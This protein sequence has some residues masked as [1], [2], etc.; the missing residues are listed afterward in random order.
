[1]F[2]YDICHLCR[3]FCSRQFDW[4]KSTWSRIFY[5][6]ILG[7]FFFKF[8]AKYYHIKLTSNLN[9]NRTLRIPT[10]LKRRGH[11]DNFLKVAL[12][13]LLVL[14]WSGLRDA[15]WELEYI[16]MLSANP[17]LIARGLKKR[18]C[19]LSSTAE[20]WSAFICGPDYGNKL[21]CANIKCCYNMIYWYRACMA[22][23]LFACQ[24]N[25]CRSIVV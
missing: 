13:I 16:I 19:T 5:I 1:M 6:N 17:M 22:F 20:Y 21:L 24:C 9:F 23:V 4:K 3:N 10:N 15:V 8:V 18:S 14:Y 12:L 11:I 2:I 25:Y 7:S